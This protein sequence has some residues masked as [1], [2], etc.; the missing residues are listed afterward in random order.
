MILNTWQHR[1]DSI[2]MRIHSK[3]SI[4][5]NI[6]TELYLKPRTEP[7]DSMQRNTA[8]KKNSCMFSKKLWSKETNFKKRRKTGA[9]IRVSKGLWAMKPFTW[10]LRNIRGK[11]IHLKNF[12][13]MIILLTSQ[14]RS[15]RFIKITSWV[16]MNL[17][18]QRILKLPLIKDAGMTRWKY[19]E[20]IGT[21][22][23]SRIILTTLWPWILKMLSW[24]KWE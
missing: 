13:L 22:R 7:F 3:N 4:L 19:L 20:E 1:R 9:S 12:S 23:P 6:L 10:R 2:G 16:L 24:I 14:T 15:P 17:I 5:R 18:T 8:L 21:W 11:E